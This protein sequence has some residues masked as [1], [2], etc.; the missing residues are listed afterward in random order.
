MACRQAQQRLRAD[1]PPPPD[2]TAV[3]IAAPAGQI[4]LC[5]RPFDR[6]ATEPRPCRAEVP[7]QASAMQ[8]A[9]SG[10][11]SPVRGRRRS[12]R[13]LRVP[14]GRPAAAAGARSVGT[15]KHGNKSYSFSGDPL[16]LNL[17]LQAVS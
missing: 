14:V 10:G 2:L 12:V 13:A 4:H 11:I 15:L 17:L 3:E 8:E 9:I 7:A 5:R 16:D 6:S 1:L